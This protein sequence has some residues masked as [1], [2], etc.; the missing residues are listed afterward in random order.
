MKTENSEKLVCAIHGLK[1][2]DHI[3]SIYETKQEQ[4]S[5]VIPYIKEG[6]SKNEKC[7]YIADENT[8]DEVIEF[9]KKDI[10]LVLDAIAEGALVILG[11]EDSYLRY[12]FFEPDQMLNFL[13]EQVRHAKQ[14]GFKALR[15]TGEASWALGDKL[16]TQ[17]LIEYEAKVNK[18]L[19]EL[20]VSALCQYNKNQFAPEIVKN[21]LETHPTV[22]YNGLVC[23]NYHYI[24]T[25]EFLSKRDKYDE[26]TRMLNQMVLI[27]KYVEN[28]RES[29]E[30]FKRAITNA[31]LPMLIYSTNG[32]VLQLNKQWTESTGYTIQDI[33]T[34]DAWMDKA[35]E[36]RKEEVS[37]KVNEKFSQ[38]ERTNLGIYTIKIKSGD[39][40]IW[41][42][43]S[44]PL[45]KTFEGDEM[46]IFTASDVTELMNK[47]FELINAKNKAEEADQLKSEFLA[48]MS[49]EIRTPINTMM[50]YTSLIKD[51]AQTENNSDLDFCFDAIDSSSKR[52]IRTID[53][54]LN[55]SQLQAGKYNCNFRQLDIEKE[56]IVPLVNE[57]QSQ[58]LLKGLKLSYQIEKTPK[59]Y[60]DEY[61]VIQIFQNLIDNAIKYTNEGEVIL[62]ISDKKESVDISV[63]D[64]GIGISEE[65]IERLFEPFSQ[66][67]HGYTR[68]YD[69]NGL[70][71]SLVKGYCELNNASI[72]VNS[73]KGNGTTF[74]VS[75][76]K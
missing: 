47:E 32:K 51:L 8:I 74:T 45:G 25:E 43:Y 53:L 44:S 48:Q 3:C 9:L 16:L 55:V 39:K 63:V 4:L 59:I 27:E 15:V 64:S 75:F 28:L 70:G 1:I 29:E 35:F 49:H 40:R 60:A 18:V 17:Q 30:R 67:E 19:S 21:V 24:P 69:G 20:D 5:A 42:F 54:I 52:L 22:I 31:P 37:V 41:N 72:K 26:A 33:P 23:K 58:A 34:I 46:I 36:D 38:Y 73:K 7:V 10:S 50:N 66:E 57:M 12:G 71:L 11:K 56:V 65:F 68:R 76:K 13:T 6:L 61:T 62:L 14:Q 2:H